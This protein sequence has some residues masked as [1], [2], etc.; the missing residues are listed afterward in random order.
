M[1]PRERRAV[2]DSLPDY[3]PWGESCMPE[4]DPHFEPKAEGRETLRTYF[5]R[6]GR[7]LY[8]SAELPVY[9]PDE[10]RF[11]PDLLAVRDVDVHPRKKWVVSD[12]GKGLDWVLEIIVSG[13][14][15][16]DL[17]ENVARYARLLIPE[18][19]VF[20]RERRAL[21]GWVLADPKIGI[22]RPIVPQRGVFHS[23]ALGL[24][25]KLDG[26]RLRFCQ[27]NAVI[28]T[29]GEVILHLEQEVTDLVVIREN[30]VALRN[31]AEQRALA[32]EQ[33]AQEVEQ[34]LT[35]EQQR[36]QEVE[37]KLTRE[38]QRAH[39]AE[40]RADEAAR[41]LAEALRELERLRGGGTSGTSG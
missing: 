26:D 33:R 20:D 5:E 35:R 30:E 39:E 8:V 3:I 34:K 16:K 17:E 23:A 21:R 1:S 22:Y 38:Q 29:P 27:G 2:L 36:A 13:D 6:T 32:A 15:R 11:S 9:Y 40:Q 25:L 14:R 12:E 10:T 24:D 37:Q 41:Q 7:K 4:G 19:F 31:E 28:L 18:Y